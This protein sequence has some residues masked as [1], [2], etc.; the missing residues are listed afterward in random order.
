M[1]LY[2]L[3][4]LSL[5]KVE[6]LLYERGIEICHQEFPYWWGRLGRCLPPRSVV[7]I[8]KYPA[9]LERVCV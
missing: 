3:S 2:I 5:R 1:M 7:A 8:G 4:P 6:D 9:A